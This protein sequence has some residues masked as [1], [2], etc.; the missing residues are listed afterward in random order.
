MPV[1]RRELLLELNV[2]H[3]GAAPVT[4]NL[5]A[6]LGAAI[7]NESAPHMDYAEGAR[8]WWWVVPM[9]EDI[10]RG[11]TQLADFASTVAANDLVTTVD[12]KTNAISVAGFGSAQ[13][14]T[15]IV[16]VPG[17]GGNGTITQAR[18]ELL[19]PP[20]AIET[21]Q[22]FLVVG[23][24]QAAPVL[25]QRARAVASGFDGEFAAAERAWAGLWRELF[26]PAPPVQI[27][28][29]APRRFL[30]HL[31]TLVTEDTAIRRSYYVGVV[32][33]LMNLHLVDRQRA[34]FAT[35]GPTASVTNLYLW[36]TCLNSALYAL[37]DRPSFVSVWAEWLS[38]DIHE[39]FSF[40]YLTGDAEVGRP[41]VVYGSCT[42]GA[43]RSQGPWYAFNDNSIFKAM[44]LTA[45]LAGPG[46]VLPLRVGNHT[47]RDV[48]AQTALYWQKLRAVNATAGDVGMDG[49][50]DYG[51]ARNLLECVPTY[52]HGVPALNAYNVFMMRTMAALNG[53]TTVRG[54][55]PTSLQ[56][57][58]THL[59]AA[60]QRRYVGGAGG[61][62]WA[63][64]YPDGSNVTV[65]HVI[66]FITIAPALAADLAPAQKREMAAFVQRELR[67]PHWL[68]AL[69]PRDKAAAE[70]DRKDH[71]PWGSY[72]GWAGELVEAF[73]ALGMYAEAVRSRPGT[74]PRV[75]ASIAP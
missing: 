62:V 73:C 39:H 3:N 26:T 40:D 30:G 32:S 6:E 69:S 23:Y 20:G 10:Q 46:A 37:L 2:S 58:A 28:T 33:F 5:T 54:A 44:E 63:C 19:V 24:A 1:G 22:L 60:V 72:D 27:A 48:M 59:T 74:I 66:D 18:W 4:I 52:M 56:E 7:R 67:V 38:F 65:R 70:S 29:V 43:P 34:L 12:R 11:Q 45:R 49:L 71:G 25:T 50:A 15:R 42:E 9:P 51:S 53:S 75:V 13:P 14:P 36:D 35:A 31:P 55:D 17:L 8:G 61:G 64:L 21:V 47:V 16:R 57:A 41:C 68:R